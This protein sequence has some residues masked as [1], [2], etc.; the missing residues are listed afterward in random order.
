MLYT[1]STNAFISDEERRIKTLAYYGE[2]FANLD[3]DDGFRSIILKQL[4]TYIEN[5]EID[6]WISYQKEETADMI[7]V[8]IEAESF[9][10]N[11][12][13]HIFDITT[14][15][16][17]H[18]CMTPL[19]QSY[20][21][22]LD[23]EV[24]LP[25]KIEAKSKDGIYFH[26]Q[27]IQNA[28][29]EILKLEKKLKKLQFSVSALGETDDA[30][31]NAIL[32]RWK[33]LIVQIE[34][35]VENLKIDFQSLVAHKYIELAQIENENEAKENLSMSLFQ[36]DIYLNKDEKK[37]SNQT[38]KWLKTYEKRTGQLEEKLD[39]CVKKIIT[40]A[41]SL[42][43]KKE[44]DVKIDRWILSQVE[45]WKSW[46]FIRG[47]I[48][49]TKQYIHH[50]GI[51]VIGFKLDGVSKLLDIE[52][53]R[54]DERNILIGFDA[55]L[56]D[57]IM[58][59]FYINS[60]NGYTA[61]SIERKKSFHSVEIEKYDQ[62][63]SPL[64]WVVENKNWDE[65]YFYKNKNWTYKFIKIEWEKEF[66][67]IW[68]Q[69]V[70]DSWIPYFGS[71]KN[72]NGNMQY[73]YLEENTYVYLEIEWEREFQSIN[74]KLTDFKGQKALKWVIRNLK[75]EEQCFYRN[76]DWTYSFL[77]INWEKNIAKMIWWEK[78]RY[79]SSELKQDEWK[80]QKPLYWEIRYEITSD[81]DRRDQTE[82]KYF[83]RK[84]NSF[85]FLDIDWYN[86]F[87]S[88]QKGT[89]R[90]ENTWKP[91]WWHLSIKSTHDTY[92]YEENHTLKL[93]RIEWKIKEIKRIDKKNKITWKPICGLIGIYA[94]K[95]YFFTWE[96]WEYKILKIPEIKGLKRRKIQYF[97]E[98]KVL[99]YDK[100]GH[101]LTWT[102]KKDAGK[103]AV[104]YPFD[105]S[106]T[107]LWE[108]V[109]N[110]HVKKIS[111]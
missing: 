37:W 58:K 48:I 62:D 45:Q 29:A 93:F 88:Y 80:D 16:Q 91:I 111:W 6:K 65:Q 28:Q 104:I 27:V 2:F 71:I 52:N 84:G 35:R 26:R 50:N 32:E 33:S 43:E 100:N 70:T 36:A 41:E 106:K 94:D 60:I 107:N 49:G 108:K 53:M 22:K 98:I 69:N 82:T 24:T 55:L 89:K 75:W 101:P 12:A 74:Y 11:T 68:V 9:Q 30:A 38:P 78:L 92:F 90:N 13:K 61:L 87:K 15:L 42:W 17:A 64:Y 20:P 39:D 34:T 76:S 21:F 96:D 10:E 54:I 23:E 66:K 105:L 1:P 46:S 67:D 4:L 31:L 51:E 73:F 18:F 5:L 25:I 7:R 3:F 63:N 95:Q 83:Y 44:I 8:I 47:L 109:T 81:R 19:L 56:P 77:E 72:E 103:D 79:I 14:K 102:Y 57:E 59:Y 110:K 99:E 40:I 85:T 97:R 86:I